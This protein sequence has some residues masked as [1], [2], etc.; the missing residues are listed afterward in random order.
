[1]QVSP[2]LQ[3]VMALEEFCQMCLCLKGYHDRICYPLALPYK[4]IFG[5]LFLTVNLCLSANFNV[6]AS[7]FHSPA[8]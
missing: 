5:S 2:Y 6:A 1:M 7:S 3:N 8:P 4:I